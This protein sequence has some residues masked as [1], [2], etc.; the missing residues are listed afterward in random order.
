MVMSRE[1]QT[2][3]E[4]Q[5]RAWRPKQ[6]KKLGPDGKLRRQDSLGHFATYIGVSRNTV[7]NWLNRGQTPEVESVDT[8]A[9]ALGPEI[10]DLLSLPRPDPH[11]KLVIARWGLLPDDLRQEIVAKVERAE[12]RGTTGPGDKGVEISKRRGEAGN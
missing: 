1:T 11:L 6:E 10:Y 12:A 5:F 4:A 9:A 2:W 8:I 3:L 7:Q